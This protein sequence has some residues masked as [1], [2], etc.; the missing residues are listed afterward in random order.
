MSWSVSSCSSRAHRARSRSDASM[1]WCSARWVA[2]CAEATAIDALAAKAPSSRLSSALNS[3]PSV[4]RSK[5]ATTPSSQSRNTSGTA[6]VALA[7]TAPASARSSDAGTPPLSPKPADWRSHGRRYPPAV[8]ASDPAVWVTTS[9][10]PWASARATP[11][12]STRARPRLTT[13]SRTG[14]SS[15]VAP[16]ARAISTW[17]SSTSTVRCSSLWRSRTVP[18]RRAFSIAMPAQSASRSTASSSASSNAPPDFSVR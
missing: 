17:V 11:R 13:S 5:A 12:A 3:G 18:Y 16:I 1:L 15:V 10:S 8:A 14:S 4:S 6:S 2:R 9:S 7:P